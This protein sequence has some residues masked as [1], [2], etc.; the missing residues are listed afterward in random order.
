VKKTQPPVR[1]RKALGENR[2]LPVQFAR[3]YTRHR[4]R[5]A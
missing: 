5:A 1:T 3:M 4:Q 2:D